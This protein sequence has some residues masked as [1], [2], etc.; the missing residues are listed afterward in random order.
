MQR[1]FRDIPYTQLYGQGARAANA[2]R[3]PCP[4]S[5]SIPYRDL[6]IPA[7]SWRGRRIVVGKT[8]PRRPSYMDTRDMSSDVARVGIPKCGA[9]FRSASASSVSRVT[10]GD[11]VER[12]GGGGRD[13]RSRDCA[14]GSNRICH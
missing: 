6:R 8:E 2:A 11:E 12:G 14:N 10:L 1:W 7:R 5:A 9:L 13:A 4:S 3:S